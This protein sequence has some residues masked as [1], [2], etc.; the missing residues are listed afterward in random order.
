MLDSEHENPELIWNEDTRKKVVNELIS[1]WI[2][3]MVLFRL[4]EL[5]LKN[6]TNYSSL[7]NKVQKYCGVYQKISNYLCRMLRER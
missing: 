6:V 3:K 1:V 2:T 5:C 7:K 4:L